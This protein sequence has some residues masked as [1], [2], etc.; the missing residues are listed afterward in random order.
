MVFSGITSDGSAAGIE[1]LTEE[2][3]V[4][5]LWEKLR[6]EGYGEWPA[7]FQVVLKISSS[8]GYAMAA[9]YERHVV[10]QR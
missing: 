5:E 6:K 10:L 2:R 1:Y 4:A 8:D 3:A 7:V 9:R